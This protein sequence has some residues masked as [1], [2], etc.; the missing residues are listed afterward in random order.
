MTPERWQ[1][2]KS[3]FERALD[4]PP[5]ACDAFLEQVDESPSVVAEV[6]KL[7]AGDAQAG[8]FLADAGSTQTA[9][10]LLSPNELVG[11]HFRIVSL[12]G[13]GGMGVVYRA[14]DLLLSRPVALKFLPG[15]QSGTT[16]SL[17]RLKREARAAA[18]LNHPNICVVYETGEYQGQPFIAMEL[19]EGQTLR[20]RIGDQPL[21]TGEL[22]EWAVQIADG[23]E[24][25]HQ[26]GI[27]HRDIKPA[28]IFITARGQAKILDFGLAKVASPSVKAAGAPGLTGLLAGEHLTTPG[29]A[30]GTVPYMSPEQARGEELD[31]RTDLFSFGAVLYEMATGKPAFTGGT[32]A[33]IH[34]AILGRAPSASTAN[35]RIPREL[36]HIISKALEKDRDLRYQHAADVRADL[37]RLKRDTESSGHT[38]TLPF[39]EAPTAQ[40]SGRFSRKVFYGFVAAM[41][42]LALGFGWAWFNS[43][44]FAVRGTLSERQLTHNTPEN[45]VLGFQISP[46]GKYLAYADTKSLHLRVIDTGEIHDISLPEELQ[47]QIW[48]VAWFPD[49]EKLLL[50]V[51]TKA[52]GLAIWET[53]IFGGTPHN[54][55]A[56]GRSAVVS[57]QGSS[58]AFVGGHGHEI[59]VMGANGENPRKVFTS[60]NEPF[61]ALAWSPAGQRLAYIKTRSERTWFG[62]SIETV[63]L[64]GG[65]PSL[66][67][68]DPGLYSEVSIATPLVWFR[69]GRLIYASTERLA[70]SDFN[71]WDIMTDPRTGKAS[72]KPAKITNWSGV[73]AGFPSVSSDGRRLAVSKLRLRDDVYVAELKE[74]G[75]RLDAP[76]R[77]TM[78]DST[79]NP[80]AWTRDSGTILFESDRTG[81]IQIFRQRPQQD[82]AQPLIQGPDDETGAELSPDGSWILY[83]AT[84]NGGKSPPAS[85]R[86]MR[87]PVSGGPPEQVLEASIKPTPLFD[88]SSQPSGFCVFTRAEQR[89]LV[90]Y[91]LDPLHGLGKQ[92]AT[93]QGS[94]NANFHISPE[95]TRLAIASAD[96][97]GEP[98]RILDLRNGGV[99]RIVQL[100][101]GWRNLSLCWAADGNALFAAVQSTEY[102]IVRIELDGKTRVLLNRGRNQWL[103]YPCPSPD[104]RYLAFSQ[105]TFESNVWLLENF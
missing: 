49:G 73:I 45:R 32:T 87:W 10:A 5:A 25:A 57:P 6:R 97:P 70:S 76:R 105:Q 2:V 104:G 31:A 69:D 59:W 77:L 74:Q 86:L 83:W 67:I 4:Q 61:A 23:L 54:L 21:N 30:V 62:G 55:R 3:L 46:D 12:L 52:E 9:A 15:G 91:A 1:R 16:Q 94:T 44:W 39:A 35:A 100:P 13:Q 72:G 60:E 80:D 71:L 7:I 47:A 51:Q 65:A 20:H 84:D 95:G 50:T 88:C 36:D 64:E 19:L 17:E 42:L 81:R 98:V 43:E 22:L 38:S 33:I 8:S 78:S 90:F 28:N 75:T 14:E 41:A 102:L 103:S 79:D 34:E 48:G 18:A 26:A 68:S 24:A 66:V 93:T 27:V 58:I 92:V 37:K 82:T 11:G 29:V 40:R 53:S 63:A 85:M 56:N 101:Q 96:R 99:E 89:R